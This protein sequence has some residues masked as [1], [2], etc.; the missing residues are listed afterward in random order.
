MNDQS[1]GWSLVSTTKILF[2][3]LGG[4]EW[5]AVVGIERGWF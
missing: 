5:K 3:L 1:S 4:E 2:S